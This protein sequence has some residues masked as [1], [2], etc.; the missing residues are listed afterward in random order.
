MLL[1]LL[2]AREGRLSH[3]PLAVRQFAGGLPG[4]KR[5]TRQF[6]QDVFPDQGRDVGPPLSTSWTAL[7]NS[8]AA[9]RFKT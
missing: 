7:S 3:F 8:M 6:A 4:P 2:T 9:H 1:L 5:P